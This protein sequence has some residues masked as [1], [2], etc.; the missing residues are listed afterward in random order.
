MPCVQLQFKEKTD[1]EMLFSFCLQRAHEKEFFI[2]KAIGWG[3]R[4]YAWTNKEAVKDFVEKNR[5]S[6]APLSIREALKNC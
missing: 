2:R 5:A 1:V 4:Q 6:F 3:L